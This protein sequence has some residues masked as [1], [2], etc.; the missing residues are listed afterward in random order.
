MMLV[1]ML[2]PVQ[3]SCRGVMWLH[4]T[5]TTTSATLQMNKLLLLLYNHQLYSGLV[6]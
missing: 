5:V 6:C 2:L 3:Y 4:M 1:V